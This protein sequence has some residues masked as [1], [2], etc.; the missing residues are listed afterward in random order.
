M[1]APINQTRNTLTLL[2]ARATTSVPDSGHGIPSGEQARSGNHTGFTE[3]RGGGGGGAKRRRGREAYRGGIVG[4]DD[5]GGGDRAGGVK[6]GGAP[7]ERGG[8]ARGGWVGVEPSAAVWNRAPEFANLSPRLK[9]RCGRRQGAGFLAG[10]GKGNQAARGARFPSK[11]NVLA[12][13]VSHVFPLPSKWQMANLV[14]SA[15]KT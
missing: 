9:S 11:T 6:R 10:W 4:V 8:E 14:R 7:A 2:R 13:W 1:S 5:G 15:P 12:C 3:R